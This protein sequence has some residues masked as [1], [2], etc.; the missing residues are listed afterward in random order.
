MDVFTQHHP[1]IRCSRAVAYSLVVVCIAG[2]SAAR[3]HDCDQRPPFDAPKF[4]ELLTDSWG[5]MGFRRPQADEPAELVMLEDY[6]PGK[7]PVVFVHGLLSTP[8]TWRTMLSSLKC[9]ERISS[10]YQ[11]WVFRYPTGPS[12]LQSANDLRQALHATVDRID[13][14]RTDPALS[15]MVLV[16]HSMGGLLAKL[17]VT[18]SEGEL[19]NAIANQPFDALKANE[20]QRQTIHD[21]LYFEPV[22]YVKRVVYIATPHRGSLWSENLLG[23][24]GRQFIEFPLKLRSDYRRLVDENAKVLDIPSVSRLPTS[25]DHLAPHNPI[26]IATNR[27][28]YAR[29]VATHS[30][31]GVGRW[32]PN[33]SM[34]DGIVTETSARIYGAETQR[35][36]SAS[37]SGIQRQ[38][39]TIEE[40]RGIL[41]RHLAAKSE[42]RL[43]GGESRHL[44][45]P[46]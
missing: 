41:T 9:D 14:R 26:I 45:S 35:F 42:P 5:W 32:L 23:R 16:G 13:P 19:W 27:L 29:G 39:Q 37:H 24:L 12:F 33:W 22:P 21:A 40:V 11:F 38:K 28:P 36:I 31:V 17:Q 43:L 44:L 15:N 30:I 8:G 46:P 3:V 34:G 7:I 20:D 10:R 6:Q 18:R 25:L 2:C 4:R 1:I